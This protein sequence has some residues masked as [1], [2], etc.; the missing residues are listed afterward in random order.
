MLIIKRKISA[1]KYTFGRVELT[2]RMK[3]LFI[4]FVLLGLNIAQETNLHPNFPGAC[5][6]YS[7]VLF[8]LWTTVKN[9]YSFNVALICSFSGSY[10]PKNCSSIAY[11]YL[12]TWLILQF[13]SSVNDV[14]FGF[15][16]PLS[17]PTLGL[18]AYGCRNSLTLIICEPLVSTCW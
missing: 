7:Y 1:K 16:G 14:G 18:N 2:F 4:E 5:M 12:A 8:F 10:L 11:F 9:I 15:A 17:L 13:L 3:L 6:M